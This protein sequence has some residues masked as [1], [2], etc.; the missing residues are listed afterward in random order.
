MIY[1]VTYG[2]AVTSLIMGVVVGIQ[3][4]ANVQS[5][6][7]GIRHEPATSALTG[8]LNLTDRTLQVARHE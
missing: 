5:A 4:V 2:F 6:F 1:V 3:T 8:H 7:L